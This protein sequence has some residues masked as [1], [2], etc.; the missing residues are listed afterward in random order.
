MKKWIST[1]FFVIHCCS[2]ATTPQISA[3][4]QTDIKNHQAIA[5]AHQNAAKCLASGKTHE[6]CLRQLQ[7][8]CKGLAIGRYCGMRHNH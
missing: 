3:E 5:A 8:A 6:I 1:L 4:I 7:E 2:Y